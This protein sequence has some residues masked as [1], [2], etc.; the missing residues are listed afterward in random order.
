MR[1]RNTNWRPTW[2]VHNFFFLSSFMIERGPSPGA[3]AR[4]RPTAADWRA[5]LVSS[6]SG[7]RRRR[8]R[9]RL[10]LHW[11]RCRSSC[12]GATTY[13]AAT[14]L[15]QRVTLGD[16][17][18]LRAAIRRAVPAPRALAPPD[19][20]RS[21]TRAATRT[22]HSR[23]SPPTGSACRRAP[24]R[25][26]RP[27]DAARGDRLQGA[28]RAQLRAASREPHG[29]R[30]GTRVSRRRLLRASAPRER[31]R[32]LGRQDIFCPATSHSMCFSL[33]HRVEDMSETTRR[34]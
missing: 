26:A 4:V 25:T 28:P 22:R 27:G 10:A 9:R 15:A 31:R 24:P 7:R 12:F 17:D 20:T 1:S 14:R 8:R 18:Q 30:G 5:T 29:D 32:R 23:C 33:L 16:P 2:K 6:T 13:F 21:T 19:P 3:R 11:A 34:D